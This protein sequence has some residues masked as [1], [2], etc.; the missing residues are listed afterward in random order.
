MVGRQRDP[1]HLSEFAQALIIIAGLVVLA[2]LAR[3]P[4]G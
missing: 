1:V 4:A 3:L 2:I